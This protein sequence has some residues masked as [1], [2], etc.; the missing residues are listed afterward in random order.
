[1]LW[2]DIFGAEAGDIQLFGIAGPDG[3]V[4]LNN[5]TVL[6]ENNVSWFAFAGLR[7]PPEGWSPGIHAGTLTLSRGGETVI[8][9]R[10]EVS[11]D[12]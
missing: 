12:R 10:V 1:M 8:S 4:M 7:R 11:I 3:S 5:E 6:D 9:Q 2:A